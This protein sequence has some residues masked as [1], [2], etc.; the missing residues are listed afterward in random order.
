MVFGRVVDVETGGGLAGAAVRLYRGVGDVDWILAR[1]ATTDDTGLFVW[2]IS[3]VAAQYKLTEDDPAGHTSVSAALPPGID[4]L[5]VDANTIEFSLPD[6]PS[7]GEF[8]FT[9]ASPTLTETPTATNIATV[10]QPTPTETAAVTS[11]P[12]GNPEDIVATS[13]ICDR[14]DVRLNESIVVA[15]SAPVITDT[16]T[17]SLT[18]DLRSCFWNTEGTMATLRP[19]RLVPGQT[20]R[21]AVLGGKGTEIGHVIPME[22]TFVTGEATIYLPAILDHTVHKLL[23]LGLILKPLRR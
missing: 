11:T 19:A 5:V 3:A 9:D 10:V 13:D 12:I 20:Y 21:L 17:F 1:E 7:V 14:R 23:G 15:F 6:Q 18:I 22:C 4:G 16:V 2:S 8:V